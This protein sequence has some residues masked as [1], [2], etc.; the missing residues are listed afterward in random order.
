MPRAPTPPE[1]RGLVHF[2]TLDREFRFTVVGRSAAVLWGRDPA[3]LIGRNLWQEFPAL[4]A[5]DSYAQHSSAL[6]NQDVRRFRFFAAPY[7]RWYQF[8]L[9]PSVDGG[10]MCFFREAPPDEASASPAR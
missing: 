5:T 9:C 4:M 6:R 1:L 8:T 7:D 10:L 2:Y 3:T